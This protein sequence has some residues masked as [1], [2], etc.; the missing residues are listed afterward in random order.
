MHEGGGSA[1]CYVAVGSR[2]GMPR[3]ASL[4]LSSSGS[5]ARPKLGDTN[6]NV[7]ETYNIGQ[8]RSFRKHCLKT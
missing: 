6:G 4:V 8:V 1:K 5:M 2:V 7:T 3:D